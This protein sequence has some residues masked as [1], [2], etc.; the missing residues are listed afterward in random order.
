MR[1]YP[2]A[3]QLLFR[4][5]LARPRLVR[6][7]RLLMHHGLPL[8][9]QV[10]DDPA[11][12]GA[13][14]AHLHAEKLPPMP[15]TPAP[16]MWMAAT[17]NSDLEF[18]LYCSQQ[19]G[20]CGCS[21]V[22]LPAG[23]WTAMRSSVDRTTRPGV[24]Q[25][26]GAHLCGPL[27]RRPYDR[28]CRP[29][30]LTTDH[31]V[32]V[33]D[34][35]RL[36]PHSN[37]E[38]RWQLPPRA[39][40]V[41]SFDIECANRGRS[42][43][44]AELDEVIQISYFL[45]VGDARAGWPLRVGD[46][47]VDVPACG[48]YEQGGAVGGEAPSSSASA[49]SSSAASSSS[50]S[51]T[52]GAVRAVLFSLRR[53]DPIPGAHI[54]SYDD[55]AT[56][57]RSFVAF[58]LYTDPDDVMQYNGH[59]F[60]WPF[61]AKRMA[62]LGEPVGACTVGR[63]LGVPLTYRTFTQTSNQQGAQTKTKLEGFLGRVSYDVM[64][65]I[66]G[67][68]KLGSYGLNTVAQRFLKMN[69]A[70]VHHSHITQ[71]WKQDA[72]GRQRLGHYC[73]TD[74]EL[75][76]QL[77]RVLMLLMNDRELARVTYTTL[78][79]VH[80]SGQSKRVYQ[81]LSTFARK[82]GYVIASR[83]IE[84]PKGGFQ[85]ATV[86]EPLS[87]FYT[88]PIA[89]LD[90]ASLYPSIM[91]ALNLCI[92]TLAKRENVL[93]LPPAQQTRDYHRTPHG[94]YFARKHL[95]K[96]VLPQVLEEVLAARKRA[97]KDMKKVP[98]GSMEYYVLD[99]RQLALKVS[100]NSTYG[101][102]GA[103]T[104]QTP[105]F[106]ISSGV[107]AVGRLCISGSQEIVQRHFTVANGYAHDATS[108]YGDTDSIFVY[109]GP[110]DRAEANRLAHLAEALVNCELPQMLQ[111]DEGVIVIEYEKTYHPL[112]LV[113]KKRYAGLLYPPD[114]PANAAFDYMDIKG[115]SSAR[116]GEALLVTTTQTSMLQT[117]LETR[118]PARACELVAA[119]VRR[120]QRDE[121][122]LGELLLSRKLAKSFEALQTKQIHTELAKRM[123]DD[124]ARYPDGAPRIG[125]RV[126]YVVLRGTKRQKIYERGEDPY[127]AMKLQLPLDVQNYLDKLRNDMQGIFNVVEPP[128][129]AFE[130]KER[131][132]KRRF[133]PSVERI[134]SA[135][136]DAL[137]VC[138]KTAS[139]GDG[140]LARMWKRQRNEDDG[141]SSSSSSGADGGRR[142]LRCRAVLKQGRHA[143]C[144]GCAP[145]DD[146]DA[147][148]ARLQA[149]ADA[150]A[151]ARDGGLVDLEDL[152]A[153]CVRCTKRSFAEAMQDCGN[154][155]CPEFYKRFKAIDAV[156]R[157]NERLQ[158]TQL[159]QLVLLPSTSSRPPRLDV[160]PQGA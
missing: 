146:A 78:A 77:A 48:Y 28:E 19:T 86:L 135:G 42:F 11:F 102:I 88:D 139:A 36:R 6:A 126:P 131:G 133:A 45:Q 38:P 116:R 113:V 75:L 39:L 130:R 30:W 95:R 40:R 125:D 159:D 115:M 56:L 90:F 137:S 117:L 96:G 53:C 70:D 158:R 107:T 61:I 76:L 66:Q 118:D 124:P 74:S 18:A 51:P 1:G 111:I 83:P 149:E 141:G 136:S 153:T 64:H 21:W 57:L 100:A 15:K 84:P 138:R 98:K 94:H 81:Q 23:A 112:L 87:G 32:V 152:L 25:P 3:P 123:R 89:T 128:Q 10:R 114:A 156:D 79:I 72:Q 103:S 134:F 4:V 24:L 20:L 119:A 33:N 142:C 82:H 68:H 9:R 92:T 150:H 16:Q 8:S 93:A 73:L 49:A 34:A 104:A 101:F 67:K 37:N 35:S 44:D 27:L 120:L 47:P 31:V 147:L 55:E 91:M 144:T 80:G 154:R 140:P 17:Y 41:A 13:V 5:S 127:T 26:R 54:F 160:V 145:A 122:H 50:S 46:A 148:R 69:K 132:A 2:S 109:W 155:E 129:D 108:V 85:G 65:A 97:K 157:A 52:A 110:V 71:L 143:L 12:R 14:G 106:E 22:T 59:G 121:V 7:V 99:G 60:D 58:M 62:T 43:P 29:E 105:C 63:Q 151:S